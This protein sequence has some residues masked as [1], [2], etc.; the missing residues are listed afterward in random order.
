MAA[1]YT[2]KVRQQQQTEIDMIAIVL[3]GPGVVT[4]AHF[5]FVARIDHAPGARLPV[6]RGFIHRVFV[7]RHVD[8]PSTDKAISF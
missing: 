8:R 6:V 3:G 2:D 4:V 5:V 7:P 1:K